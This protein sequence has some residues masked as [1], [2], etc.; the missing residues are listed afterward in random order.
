[1]IAKGRSQRTG[2]EFNHVVAFDRSSDERGNR[3]GRAVAESSFHHFADYNWDPALGCPSFV[4]APV[5]DALRKN[6]CAAGDIRRY[7]RNLAPWVAP[8]K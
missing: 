4:T 6:P 8:Q 7:V 3:L 5:G 1:V 2:R